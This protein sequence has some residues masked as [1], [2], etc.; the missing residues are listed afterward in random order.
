MRLRIIGKLLF[1]KNLWVLIILVI[2]I[3]SLGASLSSAFIGTFIRYSKLNES[4][5]GKKE[6]IILTKEVGIF[7][8]LLNAPVRF[9]DEEI[10]QIRNSEHFEDVGKIIP[11][12]YRVEAR[13]D[14][15]FG[16]R[17]SLFLESIENQYLEPKFSG[18]SWS[19]NEKTIPLIVSSEF[20]DL[21]NFGFSMAM[22]FP[23]INPGN[24]ESIPIELSLSGKKRRTFKAKV[25]GTTTRVQ[26][27]LVPSEFMNWANRELA[28]KETVEPSRLIVTINEEKEG[29][30]EYLL[31]NRWK[32]NQDSLGIDKLRVLGK[33]VLMII[34]GFCLLFSLVVF[35][36][37]LSNIRIAVLSRREE[38]K[39]LVEM[40]YRPSVFSMT[41][42][43]SLIALS[44]VSFFISALA[45]H[46]F[47]SFVAYRLWE[48]R[49]FWIDGIRG[50]DVMA[51]MAF[52]LMVLG[53]SF[54]ILRADQQKIS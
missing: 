51:I 39:R 36:L 26:S 4:E 35:F 15:N 2:L 37:L 33:W 23:Q 18:F 22:G 49:L 21:Y 6:R 3:L 12:M 48:A 8:T 20:V 24:I 31:E 42:F 50:F 38:W 45:T 10:S 7:N 27:I 32:A 53:S 52:F 16:L 11:S 25:V 5:E 19:T 28:G 43:K 29:L 13:L 46:Y 40:G 1:G 17:T 9:S 47:H 41:I 54:L 44:L 30:P 34:S 14:I